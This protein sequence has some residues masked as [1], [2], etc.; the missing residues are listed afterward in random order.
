MEG[1]PL[2]VNASLPW[3]KWAWV[4]ARVHVTALSPNAPCGDCAE[5]SQA[6]CMAA[7]TG[8]AMVKEV[9]TLFHYFS[10]NS[11]LILMVPGNLILGAWV[12]RHPTWEAWRWCQMCQLETNHR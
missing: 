9:S 6:Q 1:K 8:H 5:N 10:P 7:K 4:R 11:S 12:A 2:P 3:M